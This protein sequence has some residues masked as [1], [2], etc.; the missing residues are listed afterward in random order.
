[1]NDIAIYDILLYLCLVYYPSRRD[2]PRQSYMMHSLHCARNIAL[3]PKCDEPVPRAELDQHNCPNELMNC[4]LC[5]KQV[6]AC[7]MEEHQVRGRGRF[8]HLCTQA[9]VILG[10]VR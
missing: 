6:A 10:R 5:G 7:K 4:S 1:M 3:C 9:S 2:I 8:T